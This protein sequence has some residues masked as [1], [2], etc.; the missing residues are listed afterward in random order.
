[1][2]GYEILP[3]SLKGKDAYLD[4][5][6]EELRVLLGLIQLSG[7][8]F[9]IDE[10]VSLCGVT[11]ARVLSA[12][13]YWEEA[14]FIKESGKSESIT[15]EFEQ[16]F[17]RGEIVDEGALKTSKTIRNEKLAPLIT[18][19]ETIMG[20]TMNSTE[21]KEIVA[22]YTQYGLSEEYIAMLASYVSKTAKLTPKSLVNKALKLVERD[23]DTASA[24]LVYI[25]ERESESESEFAFRRLFGI[26]DRALSKSEKEYFRKWSKEY[27]YFTNIVGEAYDIAVMSTRKAPLSYVDKILRGW[28]EAG[29]KTLDDCRRKEDRD[30]EERKAQNAKKG[31]AKQKPPKERYGNFDIEDAFAKALERSYGNDEAGD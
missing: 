14:G 10:L 31:T 30:K 27:G 23:I 3:L 8:G 26:K 16:R 28:Y 18:E 24:L 7:T 21:T 6:K 1:M 25:E 2:N 13:V 15:Y 12:I 29:C 5:S 22:L 19:C 17:K 20:R 4:A 11:K 9:E